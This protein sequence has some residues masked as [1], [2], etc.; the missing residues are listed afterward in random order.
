MKTKKQYILIVLLVFILSL[1]STADDLRLGVA[2]I[3]D[4]N[5]SILLGEEYENVVD[6]AYNAFYNSF[7]P[8]VIIESDYLTD[9]TFN[10][11]DA[12]VIVSAAALNEDIEEAI[13]DFISEGGIVAAT[14]NSGLY[15]IVGDKVDKVW[16]PELLGIKGQIFTLE[17]DTFELNLGEE[18]VLYDGSSTLVN[19]AN[20]ANSLGAFSQPSGYAPFIKTENT[21]YTSLDLFA[22][23][24][25]EIEDYFIDQIVDLIGKDYA[26]L[27]SIDYSEIKQLA[28]ETRSLLRN[29]QREYRKAIKQKELSEEIATL[30]EESLLWS[31]AMQFAV[32]NRS[33]YHLAKCTMRANKLANE[34]YEKASLLQIPYSTL[35]ARGAYW[36]GRVKIFVNENLPENP[37]IFI[38]D[39]LTERYDLKKYYPGLPVVNRGIG[40]DMTSGV[41]DRKHLLGLE[42]NPTKIFVMLG[43]NNVLYDRSSNALEGYL[44]D[45]E[46]SLLYIKENAPG[47]QIYIQSICPLAKSTGVDPQTVPKH[48]SELQLFANEHGFTY[49]DVYS[50]LTDE[51]GYL[52]PELTVDGVHFTPKGYELWTNKVNEYL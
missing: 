39:S 13:D 28:G 36:E 40:G 11:V 15:D 22:S 51:D 46:K 37:I 38:G 6:N 49:I 50:L 33:A 30:Y 3:K 42:Q 23:S 12:I 2:I 1:I 34:L 47:A 21:L 17:A 5:S 20:P 7:V 44:A 24:N 10:Y 8:A 14:Y 48:N 45:L 19:P 52:R 26:G 35:Q 25:K 27:I 18:T 9:T 31:D 43:T 41:W 32:E 4:R 29:A 16:L